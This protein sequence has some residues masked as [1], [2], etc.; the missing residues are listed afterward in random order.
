MALSYC[1]EYLGFFL[2]HGKIFWT[3][4]TVKC[5]NRL[6]VDVVESAASRSLRKG[7]ANLIVRTDT[8]VADTAADRCS[9]WSPVVSSSPVTLR[10]VTI[11]D[12]LLRSQEIYTLTA[13]AHL[14]KITAFWYNYPLMWSQIYAVVLSGK[15]EWAENNVGNLGVLSQWFILTRRKQNIAKLLT[16]QVSYLVS[17]VV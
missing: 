13:A 4:V 15:L 3:L 5:W 16:I 11:C 2:I 17:L 14:C 1:R 7:S 12:R 6:S 9:A 8:G 10:W